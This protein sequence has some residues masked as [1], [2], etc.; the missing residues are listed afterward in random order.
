MKTLVGLYHDV[1]TA[2]QVVQALVNA[3]ITRDDI[4]MVVN[5]REGQYTAGAQADDLNNAQT[6]E[7]GTATAGGA[8]TGAV[9][10]GVGGALLSLSALAIPG[11]GPVVAAG[12]LI[13]GLIGAGAGAAVGGLL[14]ALTE[15]GVPEE[16]AGFYIAGV[17]RGGTLVSAAVD[18]QEVNQIVEIMQRHDPIDV[19]EQVET[20]RNDAEPVDADVTGSYNDVR[21]NDQDIDERNA[22]LERERIRAKIQSTAERPG[23]RSRTDYDQDGKASYYTDGSQDEKERKSLEERSPLNTRTNV[24]EQPGEYDE[25]LRPLSQDRSENG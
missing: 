16:E 24:G 8:V 22:E 25:E 20:W 21:I 9:I 13:V 6:S 11:I 1:A 15:A 18:D 23:E 2:N 19:H 12:P 10:G 17:N 5:D 7:V 3:G 14:G 4:S